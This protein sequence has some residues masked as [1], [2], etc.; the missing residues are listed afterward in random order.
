MKNIS[1]IILILFFTGQLQAQYN[2]YSAPKLSANLQQFLVKGK[3]SGNPNI[4]STE[5]NGILYLSFLIKVDENI[6]EEDL[7]Q[8]KVLIGTKAGNIWT[9]LVP[10]ENLDQFILV[11]GI[12]F[13][14][15][16]EPIVV[17]M[18]LARKS[19]RTD[20][21]QKGINLPMGYSGK[22]VVVGIID[23]GFD[24]S[25]PDFF[26]TLGQKLRIKRVWEQKVSGTPPKGFAYG[27]EIIDTT[28]MLKEGTE[29]NSFSHGT[30]VAGIA[31]GS[32]FG[33]STNLKYRGMAYESDLVFVGIRPEKQEWKSMGMAS[34]IDGINYIFNYAASVY[35]PAVVNLSWGCSIG[36]NDGSSLFSQACD[37]LTGSGKIFVLSAGNNGEEKIHLQKQFSPTD[38]SLQTYIKFDASL[39]TKHTWVDVWGE[40]GKVFSINL[41]LYNAA[42]K[43]QTTGWMTLD[44]LANSF[45]LLGTD[46][47][48]LFYTISKKISDFNGR[49]HVLVDL[50]S[51]TNNDIQLSISSKQGIVHLW[52]GYVESYIGYYGEFT[53]LG[54]IGASNGDANF[55]L[56]EMS[57]TRSAITVSAYSSKNTFKN[58]QGK[59]FSYASYVSTG[60]IVPFSSHGP[61]TDLRR[62]PDISGPGLTLASAVNSYDVNYSSTGNNYSATVFKYSHPR[63]KRDYFYAEASGTSMSSPAVSGIIALML[64][65]NPYLGPNDIKKILNETAIKD[66]FTTSKP[67]STRW[68]AGKVNAYGAVKNSIK[69]LSITPSKGIKREIYV[70]P[71]PNNGN[72]N[73]SIKAFAGESISLFITDVSGKNIFFKD[74]T[75]T[76]DYQLIPVELPS[77]KC[78]IY[79]VHLITKNEKSSVRVV[80]Q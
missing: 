33:G 72:F 21:V 77:L 19:T 6:N 68:G 2:Q 16:D 38:T 42:K 15:M 50:Y 61:S 37:N 69:K 20:S 76:K 46:N 63:T 23:A 55:T 22:N 78:G 51:K 31:A 80:I 70:A 39:G 28:E 36:P 44:N 29:I 27:N 8:L 3:P 60:Q 5:L 64:Q 26:D 54:E 57:C 66:N 73:I 14:Q 32:G 17:N 24:Y 34:I 30:H 52:E 25:H 71:N 43:G 56:G 65:A 1:L 49:P 10:Q 47:D 59:S 58:I 67:D 35:K 11:D 48:T 62:K 7:K 9:L 79:F 18:D 12:N 41:S 45:I 53:S 13:I 40:T 75:S 4:I 74:L